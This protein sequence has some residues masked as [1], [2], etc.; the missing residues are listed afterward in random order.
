MT[1]R[2]GFQRR[3]NWIQLA[4]YGY[5]GVAIVGLVKWLGPGRHPDWPF[6]PQGHVFTGSIILGF[7]IYLLVITR[8]RCPRCGTR[9]RVFRDLGVLTSYAYAGN[10]SARLCRHCGLN[11]DEEWP[12]L[13][14]IEQAIAEAQKHVEPFG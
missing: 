14:T 9:L 11:F 6:T 10:K 12:P 1:P 4:L 5:C 3:L 8:I 2:N 7:L 13:T